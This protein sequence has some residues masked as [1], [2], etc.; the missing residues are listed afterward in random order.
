MGL[1]APRAIAQRLTTQ[2]ATTAAYLACVCPTDQPPQLAQLRN[3]M[4]QGHRV[5]H[6]LLHPQLLRERMCAL[7]WWCVPYPSAVPVVLW[8]DPFPRGPAA[9]E[10]Q[11]RQ[12]LAPSRRAAQAPRPQRRGAP[13]PHVARIFN[14]TARVDGYMTTRGVLNQDE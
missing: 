12:Q 13:G 1:D 7:W 8:P 2:Q 10:P 5:P 4:W 14:I 9:T 6:R 11:H 3:P